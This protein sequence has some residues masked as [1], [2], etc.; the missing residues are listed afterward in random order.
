[1]NIE[2]DYNLDDFKVNQDMQLSPVK[3]Q[4]IKVHVRKPDK[5]WFVRVNPDEAYRGTFYTLEI[6]D[7]MG[8]ELF[9]ILGAVSAE[10]FTEFHQ[11]V[12]AQTI[13]TAITKQGDVFLWPIPQ[14]GPDGKDLSWWESAR[15]GAKTAT[16]KWTRIVANQGMGAYDVYTAQGNLAEPTWPDEDFKTLLLKG[17]KGKIID[18][19]DHEALNKL[20]GMT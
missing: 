11:Y 13:Y 6:N 16:K 17:F 3:K 4:V 7:S 1:M 5:S 2:K 18:T 9:L 10:I 19:L 12:K 15:E 20:R 14:P 8:K